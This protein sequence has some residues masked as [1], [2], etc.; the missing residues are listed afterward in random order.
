MK[1]NSITN[2]AAIGLL[3]GC[4]LGMTGAFVPSHIA[5]NILWGIDSCGLIFATALLGL[6]FSKKGHDIVAAGFFIFIVAES[7][8]LLSTTGDLNKNIPAFGAGTCLWALSI[9]IVS[10]QKVFPLLVRAT[11]AI[12]TILFAI[13]AF[14][15]F[16]DHPVNALTQPLPFFAY[17]FYAATLVGWA[18]TIRYRKHTF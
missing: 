15:I 10:S 5:R 11:G 14:L 12:T 9:G 3:T 13:A 2:I 17:P 16:T 7:V 1:E 18:W 6:Y 4:I 8:I